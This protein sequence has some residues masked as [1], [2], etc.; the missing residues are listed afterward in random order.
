MSIEIKASKSELNVHFRLTSFGLLG[1]N[2]T[3]SASNSLMVY[4]IV[5]FKIKKMEKFKIG[6]Y[7]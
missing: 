3:T 4:S 6:F 7:I 2:I 1:E 5:K